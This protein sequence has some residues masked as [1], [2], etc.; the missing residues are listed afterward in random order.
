MTRNQKHANRSSERQP[1]F[2]EIVALTDTVCREHLNEEYAELARRLTADLIRE[3]FDL[4]GRGQAKTWACAVVYTIGSSNFL[5]DKSQTPHLTTD[6]LCALFDVGKSTA[7][8][9]ATEIRKAFDIWQ[10]DP[11]WTLPSRA[12]DNPLI[13]MLTVN[14]V[15]MDIRDAPRGAQEEALRLGLIPYIPGDRRGG[16]SGR[17]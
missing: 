3:R 1:R 14:G 8:A 5:F 11:R 10:L 7:S 9:K 13:W 12:E 2:D 4:V 6:E 16:T 17:T 15:V